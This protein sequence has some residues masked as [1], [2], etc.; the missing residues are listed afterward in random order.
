[1]HG[2]C[3]PEIYGPDY[4]LQNNVILVTINYRVGVLGKVIAGCTKRLLSLLYRQKALPVLMIRLLG[5]PAM[6][7]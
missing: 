7:A 3:G 6:L 1:M 4:I 2:S 5:Y